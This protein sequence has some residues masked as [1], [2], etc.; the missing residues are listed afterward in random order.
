MPQKSRW[1]LVTGVWRQ[2]HRTIHTTTAELLPPY[3]WY[4][5]IPEPIAQH[6]AAGNRW[7]IAT[8]A[9]YPPYPPFSMQGRDR[10]KAAELGV[11][12][13]GGDPNAPWLRDARLDLM[14][15]RGRGAIKNLIHNL[16][17]GKIDPLRLG[18][19]KF[20]KRDHSS[21]IIDLNDADDFVRRIGGCERWTALWAER[22]KAGDLPVSTAPQPAL[23]PPSPIAV[24]QPKERRGHYVTFL[25]TFM[26]A[27]PQEAAGWSHR[28]ITDKFVDK[29]PSLGREGKLPHKRYIE[30]QV[31]NLRKEFKKRRNNP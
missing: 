3:Y 2:L 13:A 19:D 9:D 23:P 29:W 22:E 17:N 5:G 21:D 25:E 27:L 20:G 10:I 4:P 7:V 12:L 31:E 24:E 1:S 15:E 6:H 28:A 30:I 18:F 8:E 26:L 11:I 14:L 16:Q